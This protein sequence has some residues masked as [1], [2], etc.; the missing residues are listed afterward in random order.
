MLERIQS[1]RA[2][3][4]VPNSI[5]FLSLAFGVAAILA[6][7][8]GALTTAGALILISYVLDLFDGEMARRLEAGSSFG[9]QLDSLVD[10]VSLGTAPAVLAFFHLHERLDGGL[11]TAAL[12]VLVILY[13]V[14]GAFRLARFNLLPTKT[15]QTDSVGLT[16][17]TSGAT[18]TLAVA[19]DLAST[20]NLVP[21]AF[22]LV[23]LFVLGLLMVS[24]IP[25]P[26]L[27]WVFSYRRANL[28]YLLY[29][30]ITLIL[31]RLPF[32]A[33]WFLFNIGFIGA[34]IVRAVARRGNERA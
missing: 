11:L 21:P 32:V 2:R 9:L 18:L 12:W 15:G 20:G 5:T 28:V 23:F 14:A 19:T 24:R 27:T 4:V 30:A 7:A 34:A 25:F 16:I 26:S 3:Y 13:V 6:A 29:F 8:T 10:M 17:S 33:V 22:Y 1:S 31:L